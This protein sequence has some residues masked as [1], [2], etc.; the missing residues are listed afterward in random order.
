MNN[1]HWQKDALDGLVAEYDSATGE[2]AHERPVAATLGHQAR[3]EA[4]MA[5]QDRAAPI[6]CRSGCA[7]CCHL[8]VSVRPH[9]AMTL[10]AAVREKPAEEQQRLRLAL[11]QNAARVRAMSPLEHVVAQLPCG[12]LDAAGKCSVYAHRPSACRRYHSTSVDACKASFDNPNDLRSRIA[13]SNPRVVASLTLELGYRK[14]LEEKRRDVGAY[15][16]HTAVLEALDDESG[17]H[18]R[19][20]RGAQV[21]VQA[22]AGE[23]P[24][25]VAA[26]S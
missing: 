4:R 12:F 13:I 15:E 1:D 21:L 23:A 8:R 2:R 17:C 19:W 26:N 14:V 6:A 3:Y 7:Y 9:E 11:E 24:E 16:L 20:S 5:V 25:Q 22:L 10:A 18:E